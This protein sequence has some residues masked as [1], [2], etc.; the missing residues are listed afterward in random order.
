MDYLELSKALNRGDGTSVLYEMRNS[1]WWKSYADKSLDRANELVTRMQN[2]LL[3]QGN[4]IWET[5]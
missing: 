5:E 3:R 4:W 2:E 1:Q